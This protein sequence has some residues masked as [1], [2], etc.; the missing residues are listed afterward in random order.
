VW[1]SQGWTHSSLI[2]GLVWGTTQ[3][4]ISDGSGSK[5]PKSGV[6]T[7]GLENFPPKHKF[8]QFFALKVKK[9]SLGLLK[10][11]PLWRRVDSL[12]T[13]GQKYAWVC[14]GQGPSLPQIIM[15]NVC[16]QHACCYK[17][18]KQISQNCSNYYHWNLISSLMV[19]EMAISTQDSNLLH[20]NY[21]W[22][23]TFDSLS[24][25]QPI[26]WEFMI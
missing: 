10:K 24:L 21:A 26:I 18:N 5:Q 7:L 11:Y 12:F 19:N 16:C 15:S 6:P 13:A 4:Q 14:S 1:R 2:P 9:I 25:M 8:F 22:N 20:F 17:G 3:P 23:R